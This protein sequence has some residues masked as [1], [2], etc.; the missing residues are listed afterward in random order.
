MESYIEVKEKFVDNA[1][2]RLKRSNEQSVLYDG[3]T[4]EAILNALCEEVNRV[5]NV[6]AKEIIAS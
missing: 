1:A 3:Q 4:V 2:G 6:Q 5:V